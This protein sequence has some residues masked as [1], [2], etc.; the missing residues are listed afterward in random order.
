MPGRKVSKC[1]G[2]PQHAEGA[3]YIIQTWNGTEWLPSVWAHY[4]GEPG[5][6][7]FKCKEN[8]TWNGTKCVA[9][10]FA[11]FPECSNT[12]AFPCKDSSTGTVWS[13]SYDRDYAEKWSIYEYF[14][15][16]F[17][18]GSIRFEGDHDAKNYAR[19]VR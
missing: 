10:D 18:S 15:L 19:C 17:E 4:G 5:E 12:S 14:A 16:E 3:E 6:C 11:S 8:Y 1:Y 9:Y 7:A 13:S 2:I